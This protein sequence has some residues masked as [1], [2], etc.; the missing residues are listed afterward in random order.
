MVVKW[1]KMFMRFLKFCLILI[2]SIC[3][4]WGSAIFFGPSL[5]MLI[6][7]R[8]FDGSIKIFGLEVSPDLKVYASRVKIDKIKYGHKSEISGELRAVS[9]SIDGLLKGAPKA[10]LLAGPSVLDNHGAFSS[11]TV[12]IVPKALPVPDLVVVNTEVLDLEMSE[13]LKAKSVQL[14]SYFNVSENSFSNIKLSGKNLSHSG[15]FDFNSD[16]FF[17]T[18][19][20]FFLNDLYKNDLPEIEVDF[21]KAS[22]FYGVEV[23]A[24]A[25]VAVNVTGQDYEL[26]VNLNDL[27]TPKFNLEKS[28]LVATLSGSLEGLDWD[29]FHLKLEPLKFAKNHNYISN[30]VINNLNIDASKNND[31]TAAAKLTATLGRFELVNGGQF[32]SDLSNS[33]FQ[34][35]FTFFDSKDTGN[36]NF[37]TNLISDSNPLASLGVEGD[38]NYVSSTIEECLLNKCLIPNSHIK[39]LMKADES[40]LM[41]AFSCPQEACSLDDL[42][43]FAETENT[44]KFFNAFSAT[45]L[46]NPLMIAYF[47]RLFL[48]GTADGSGHK[49]EF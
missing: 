49:V 1:F 6:A 5:I 35:D 42:K 16:V 47:Y 13:L 10:L 2:L 22:L 23:V 45:G 31:G 46:A 37:E 41:G 15:A 3:I 34:A 44:T 30:G 29:S 25:V 36:L 9:F 14:S 48:L 11:L 40:L 7:D 21:G 19:G 17:G 20:D 38:V 32:V 27:N 18:I 43:F 24:S 8:K 12:E 28:N 33:K 26:G 4:L 39:F